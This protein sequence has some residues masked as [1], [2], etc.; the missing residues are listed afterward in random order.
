[1]GNTIEVRAQS[2]G[3]VIHIPVEPGSRVQEDAELIIVECMKLE[4]PVTAP[5]AAVVRE[6]KVGV[7][8]RIEEDDALIVLETDGG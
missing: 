2:P 8:D 4:I 7:G 5:R 3:V 1:M 6:I